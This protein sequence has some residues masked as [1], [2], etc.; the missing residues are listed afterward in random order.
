MLEGGRKRR[1]SKETTKDEIT[2]EGE[3]KQPET[4]TDEKSPATEV[5]V[6]STKDVRV[7]GLYQ[8][9]GKARNE[10]RRKDRATWVQ[11]VKLPCSPQSSFFLCVWPDRSCCDLW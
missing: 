3:H 8:T 2:R 11:R 5:K 1:P 10:P 6:G 7:D 4:R 9:K